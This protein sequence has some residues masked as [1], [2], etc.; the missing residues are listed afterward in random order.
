MKNKKLLIYGIGETAEVAYEYFT[1]DSNYEIVAFVVDKEFI[2]K[3]KLFDLPV[4]P[5]ENVEQIY[6]PETKTLSNSYVA[7]PDDVEVYLKAIY[8]F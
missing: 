5:F 6:S 8:K 3:D 4:I 1:H 7:E 2:K